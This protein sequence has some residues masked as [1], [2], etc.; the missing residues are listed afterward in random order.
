MIDSLRALTRDLLQRLQS[1]DIDL[2]GYR[3]TG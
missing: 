1:G 2:T 3:A